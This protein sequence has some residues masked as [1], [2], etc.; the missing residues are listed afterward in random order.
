MILAMKKHYV[1]K[2]RDQRDE[3]LVFD[4]DSETGEISGPSADHILQFSKGGSIP[5]HPHPQGWDLSPEPLKSK[6]DMA[7][8]IGIWHKL[9]EDL[10]EHYPRPWN[11]ETD[12]D[13]N[14]V[15]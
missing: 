6:T 8:I 1:C 13:P 11:P 9:P 5:I 15:Y 4:W 7:A 3:P 14:V 2:P 10:I 12:F